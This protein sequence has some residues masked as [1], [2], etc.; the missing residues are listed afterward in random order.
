MCGNKFKSYICYNG[1]YHEFPL[2]IVWIIAVYHLL[3]FA[4]RMKQRREA[5]T[6]KTGREKMPVEIER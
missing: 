3:I 1:R 4:L 5:A 6:N 2:Y